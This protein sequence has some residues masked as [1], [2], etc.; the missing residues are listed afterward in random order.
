MTRPLTDDQRQ[1]AERAFHAA[2]RV[3][4][5]RAH[6]GLHQAVLIVACDPGSVGLGDRDLAAAVRRRLRG[7]HGR[8]D[9]GQAGHLTVPAVVPDFT[10]GS[11]SLDDAKSG[12]AVEDEIW[13]M[14]VA[15]AQASA[16]DVESQ[17]DP[18]SE[19]AQRVTVLRE[20]SDATVLA[21][22]ALEFNDGVPRPVMR[23][24]ATRSSRRARLFYN[25]NAALIRKTVELFYGAL[26]RR[27]PLLGDVRRVGSALLDQ[28]RSL[29]R[30]AILV[31][32]AVPRF[33]L[34][35]APAGGGRAG[36]IVTV[37]QIVQPDVQC[38]GLSLT[39]LHYGAACGRLHLRTALSLWPGRRRRRPA[40]DIRPDRLLSIRELLDVVKVPAESPSTQLPTEYPLVGF[41]LVD[42]A[43]LRVLYG[44]SKSS[45]PGRAAAAFAGAVVGRAEMVRR[46][47][48]RRDVDPWSTFTLG[49]RLRAATGVETDPLWGV[50]L[51]RAMRHVGWFQS[52]SAHV[53]KSARG[54]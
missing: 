42:D 51:R 53:H 54:Q 26:K 25:A 17:V 19:D 11:P 49:L 14:H 30:A 45:G 16:D 13:D 31:A 21:A 47:H 43:F 2:V 36:R 52:A 22:A 4:V 23:R 46:L 34:R 29:R 39:N 35:L 7:R 10:R 24:R 40:P 32:G 12:P 9:E 33:V 44:V 6:N 20:L 18:L 28:D 8:S 41:D 15:D 37:P 1:I 27:V 48:L 3:G 38:C 5:P 50:A